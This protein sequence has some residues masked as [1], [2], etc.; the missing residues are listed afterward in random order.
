M[1]AFFCN[2]SITLVQKQH[3]QLVAGMPLTVSEALL[4]LA[5]LLLFPLYKCNDHWLFRDYENPFSPFSLSWSGLEPLAL[6]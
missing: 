2:D 3:K 4:A 6:G 1:V 5:Q